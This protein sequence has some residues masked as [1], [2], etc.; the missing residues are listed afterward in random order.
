MEDKLCSVVVVLTG[1]ES[2][3]EMLE[4]PKTIPKILPKFQK[5]IFDWFHFPT[6]NNGTPV[7]T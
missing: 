4:T 2:L 3:R 7:C 5:A 1:M 6:N